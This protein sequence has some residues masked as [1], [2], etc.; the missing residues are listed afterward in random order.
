MERRMRNGA[1]L[2][3]ITLGGSDHA[4]LTS[5]ATAALDHLPQAAEELLTELD[6]ARIVAD[7]AVPGDVVRMG[8]TVEF[9]TEADQKRVTLVFPADADIEAGR[10]SVLTP[11]GAALIGLT[12]GESMTWSA[13]DGRSHELTI[14]D[15][16]PPAQAGA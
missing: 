12:K 6:R 5:L 10:V 3:E 4:R 11:V 13:R 8:S 2:P 1:R 14:L 16:E 7:D 15:V 9:R